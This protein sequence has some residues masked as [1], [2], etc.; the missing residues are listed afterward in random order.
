VAAQLPERCGNVGAVE[1]VENQTT[2]FHRSHRP[3]EIARWAIST[4]PP[5]RRFPLLR[6]P[7]TKAQRLAPY[8]RS[9][10]TTKGGSTPG[11]GPTQSCILQVHA[12]TGKRW[13]EKNLPEPPPARYKSC[14]LGRPPMAGFEVTPEGLWG[15][16]RAACKAI[17]TTTRPLFL[18]SVLRGFN[19][20]TGQKLL[21]HVG[22][23]SYTCFHFH[24]APCAVKRNRGRACGGRPKKWLGGE[25]PMGLT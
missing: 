6:N 19:A 18:H 13:A 15:R 21:E 8:G 1:T 23:L 3:L 9:H 22:F 14:V 24:C 25:Y 11:R 7:K 16:G 17:P 12:W 2:V 10:H 20:H 4:F 5:R